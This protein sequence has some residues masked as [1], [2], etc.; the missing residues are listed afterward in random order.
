MVITTRRIVLAE[1][2]KGMPDSSTFATVDV[3]LP[4]LEEGQILVRTLYASVDPYMRGRMNDAKS[5]VPP[6]AVGEAISGGVVAEVVETR[7]EKWA[8]GDVVMGELPWQ[9]HSVSSGKGLLKLTPSKAP[10]S[11]SL[12]VLGMPGMTAYFGLLEIGKPKPGETIV[13]SGAAGAVGSIVGQI[14]KIL[15]CRVVGI[16][17]SEEK[18]RLLVDELGFDAAVQYKS[19]EFSKALKAACPSGVDIY[20]DNVGGNVTD[21]VFRL[22]NDFARIPVCGQISLYNMEQADRGPRLFSYLVVRRAL[23]QGFIVSDY[24]KR[25]PEAASQLGSW[26]AE[27]KL[28]YK[29]TIVSGFERLPDAFL[30]LFRGDNTGK[31]LVKVAD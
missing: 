23:A 1:R 26:L 25:F 3:T 29:E 18:A 14:G 27:G 5:Y 22:L 4:E 6:F 11:T 16:V 10:V 15:G 13:V 8:V 30:G 12:G 2:P 24:A 7:H 9:L 31:L 28:H 20:F 21:E 17:G 19:A